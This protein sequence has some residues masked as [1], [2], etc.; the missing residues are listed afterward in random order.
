MT[1]TSRTLSRRR[2]P[3]PGSTAASTKSAPIRSSVGA[4]LDPS[5]RCAPDR[6]TFAGHA[7]QFMA[8]IEPGLGPCRLGGGLPAESANCLDRDGCNEPLGVRGRASI[9]QHPVRANPT[10][11]LPHTA[12]PPAAT[13]RSPGPSAARRRACRVCRTSSARVRSSTSPARSARSSWRSACASR[14]ANRLSHRTPRPP[15]CREPST[16]LK[17]WP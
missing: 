1:R 15:S 2:A 7:A 4:R 9:Q 11:H 12:R 16:A 8:E 5:C 13:T 3:P 14:S 6:R 17:H 10:Q